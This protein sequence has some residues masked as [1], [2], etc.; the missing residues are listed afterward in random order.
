MH[1]FAMLCT[2]QVFKDKQTFIFH[3]FLATLEPVHKAKKLFKTCLIFSM[4]NNGTFRDS[5]PT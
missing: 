5:F 2:P 3:V 1:V 4:V